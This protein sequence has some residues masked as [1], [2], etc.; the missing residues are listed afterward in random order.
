MS[1]KHYRGENMRLLYYIGNHE[2]V[3]LVQAEDKDVEDL[4]LTGK[5]KLVEEKESVE[6][7][8]IDYSNLVFKKYWTEQEILNE[9]NKN[10]IKINYKP[11]IH[12]KKEVFK[13]LSKLGVKVK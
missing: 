8:E 11:E 1:I 3:G 12:T 10:E 13:K 5:Y 4:L 2:E 9:I 6:E 7:N